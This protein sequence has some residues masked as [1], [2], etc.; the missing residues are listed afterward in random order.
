MNDYNSMRRLKWWASQ[1][2]RDELKGGV[3]E[4]FPKNSIVVQKY[5][6]TSVGSVEKI[7]AIADRVVSQVNAGWTRIAIVVSAMAGETNRLVSLVEQI[8][9]K[10][11]S[12]SYDM[13][14]A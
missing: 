10:A 6:G 3:Y 8:H 11:R 9:P 14:V 1:Q 4:S 13:A 2:P 5:G 12:K 7:Q